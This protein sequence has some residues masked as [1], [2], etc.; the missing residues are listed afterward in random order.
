LQLRQRAAL[1]KKARLGLLEGSK[2]GDAVEI[3]F[4]VGND[5]V[6]VIHLVAAV[7]E[8]SARPNQSRAE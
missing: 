8:V 6:E 2:V 3:R 4:R 7:T 5:A 1:A